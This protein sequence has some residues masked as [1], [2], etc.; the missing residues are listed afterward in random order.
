MPA[1]HG[2]SLD[3]R[4]TVARVRFPRMAITPTLTLSTVNIST[5]DPP[6][7]AHFYAQL[8]GWPVVAEEPDWALLRDPAGGVGIS[9]QTETGYRRPTWPAGDGDQQM[10]LHL[11]IRVDD[12][13]L[14][15]DHAQ[16]C[17]ATLA[18]WQ[19]QD[20]VRVWLDPAGHPFCLWIET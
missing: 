6:G 18:S 1:G 19:P 14:A 9:C 4:A 20:G 13:A 15:G 3:R 11:E 17:G 16:A 12:L 7:L 10:M 8:L 5:D 2:R